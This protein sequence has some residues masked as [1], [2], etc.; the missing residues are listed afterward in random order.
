MYIKC[1]RLKYSSYIV[2]HEIYPCFYSA[3]VL[4]REDPV[5]ESRQRQKRS[6]FLKKSAHQLRVHPSLLF[7]LYRGSAPGAKRPGRD[8]D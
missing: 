5:F 2:S 4:C 7:N 1:L 6:D 3:T 8:V